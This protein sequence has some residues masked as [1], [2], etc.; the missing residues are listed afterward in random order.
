MILLNM[1][2]RWC[3]SVLAVIVT[4]TSILSGAGAYLT[5]SAEEM[6]AV[7][8]EATVSGAD[9]RNEIAGTLLCEEDELTLE[10]TIPADGVYTVWW[11]YYPERVRSDDIR[12]AFLI[13]GSYPLSVCAELSLPLSYVCEETEF[14]T[15]ADGNELSAEWTLDARWYTAA[16]CALDGSKNEPHQFTLSAGK[17]RLT[18]QM[19]DGQAVVAGCMVKTYEETP[20]YADY[21]NKYGSSDQ[22]PN[23][24][25]QVLEAEW[26]DAVSKKT[27]AAFSDSS[28][29]L[30]HPASGRLR[31]INALGGSVW[32]QAGQSATW[33]VTVPVDGWYNFSM[34][35]RQDQTNGRA[36]VRKLL[37]DGVLPFQEAAAIE[38]PYTSSWEEK[39]FA[40][41]Q[42]DP[43]RLWLTAGEHTLTLEV[44]LGELRSIVEDS[45]NCLTR[46]NAVYRRILTIT[47]AS[48]DPYRDY[49]L[50]DKIPEALDEMANLIRDLSAIKSVLETQSGSEIGAIERLIVQLERFCKKPS[51]IATQLSQYQSNISALG[52]WIYNR[53]SQPLA[54]DQLMLYADEQTQSFEECGVFERIWHGFCQFAYSF[55]EDYRVNSSD[56]EAVEVW[57]PSGRDQVQLIKRLIENDFT[58]Q[59]NIHVDTRLVTAGAVLPAVVA[60]SGPDVVLMNDPGTPVNFASRKAAYNL[61]VFSDL[62]EVL[63]RFPDSA[64]TPYVFDRNVYALPETITYPVLYYRTD[65]MEELGLTIPQTWEDVRSLIPDLNYNNMEFGLECTFNSYCTLLYQNHGAVYSD[66]GDCTTIDQQ[67][68]VAAFELFTK[69][70]REYKLPVSFD[71]ANRFRSG[72]MPVAIVS[73]T[74]CNTLEIFAPEIR[75]LWDIALVPGTL[76]EDGTLDRTI[77]CGG[78]NCMMIGATDNPSAAWEFMK[79]WTSA[80]IQEQYGRGIENRLGASARYPT[81]NTEALGKLPWAYSMYQKLYTQMG[82]VKGVPEVPGGY[83]MGRHFTNAFRKVIYDSTNAR[84]TLLD[85]SRVINDEITIKRKEFGLPTKEG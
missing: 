11:K 18:M 59:K 20:L 41:E 26:P 67:E 19:L 7:S 71:F 63:Q 4:A 10:V 33:K 62:N 85:Y 17:H 74:S 47:G 29:A 1:V 65:I 2:K 50:D 69:L 31:K 27:V 52:T 72:Q 80:S 34:F 44:A 45:Q 6:A 43:Y 38:F 76:Q 3:V 22:E 79:W 15:D 21:L 78:Q 51:K 25:V 55:A 60:G 9:V 61:S 16:V 14:P 42:G 68:G 81:A 64:V 54:L 84:K 57:V 66:S 77:A 36:T 32:S 82:Y 58:P 40:S 48:P 37:V 46:L 12:Y 75:G 35:Y 70:Y 39:V 30:V 23:D 28:S 8:C 49:D 5:V 56:V 73:Y 53:Y 24:Y 83:F 13:D